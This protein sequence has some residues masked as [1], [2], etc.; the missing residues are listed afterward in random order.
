MPKHKFRDAHYIYTHIYIYRRYSL[1]TSAFYVPFLSTL[2][3]FVMLVFVPPLRPLK[4]WPFLPI[5]PRYKVK[6][7]D[8]GHGS[9]PGW[10]ASATGQGHGLP[11]RNKCNLFHNDPGGDTRFMG[12]GGIRVPRRPVQKCSCRPIDFLE[13]LSSCSFYGN[14]LTRKSTHFQATSLSIPTPWGSHYVYLGLCWFAPL[15]QQS[16]QFMQFLVQELW[17]NSCSVVYV[18]LFEYCM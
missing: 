11:K 17:S 18:C 1:T 9:R 15:F 2:L 5:D 12:P 14:E 7:S 16:S 8:D 10:S 4:F 3:F 6:P 13:C